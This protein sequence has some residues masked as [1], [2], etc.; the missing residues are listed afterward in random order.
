LSESNFSADER[1][2]LL[3][4]VAELQQ[5][6]ESIIARRLASIEEPRI[7]SGCDWLVR[8]I[9]RA[10]GLLAERCTQV[11]LTREFALLSTGWPYNIRPQERPESAV[12]RV[13]GALETLGNLASAPSLGHPVA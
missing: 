13:N 1:F 11:G 5:V 2:Q 9:E 7:V 8:R 3:L 4:D 12:Q 6:K 10:L